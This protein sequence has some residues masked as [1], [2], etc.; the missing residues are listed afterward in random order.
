MELPITTKSE[1]Q[2][3]ILRSLLA[4]EVLTTLTGNE[5]ASTVDFRK[6]VSILRGKGVPISDRWTQNAN[7]KKRYKEYFLQK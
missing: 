2:R 5:T 1:I 7:N 3:A 6:A 4:G